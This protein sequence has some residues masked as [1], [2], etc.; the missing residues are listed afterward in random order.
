MRA[1]GGAESMRQGTCRCSEKL[2]RPAIC[3]A[4]R[5]RKFK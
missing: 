1:E 3:A 2:T 5:L 4:N